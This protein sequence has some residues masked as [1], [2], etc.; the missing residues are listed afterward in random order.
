ME[1]KKEEMMTSVG[2]YTVVAGIVAFAEN[3]YMMDNES[4][5]VAVLG[6]QSYKSFGMKSA[7][8]KAIS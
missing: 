5:S 3:C 2:Y 4:L 7:Q 8:E 6:Y 1:I